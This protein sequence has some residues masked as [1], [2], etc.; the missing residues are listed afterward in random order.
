LRYV[1]RLCGA[2]WL[3]GGRFGAP[4]LYPAFCRRMLH[5]PRSAANGRAP[6]LR[7]SSSPHRSRSAGLRRGPRFVL[8]ASIQL[9]A[10]MHPL[11]CFLQPPELLLVVEV[12][13]ILDWQD[14]VAQSTVVLV[15]IF[16]DD[17]RRLC[18]DQSLFL[19]LRNVLSYCID[20]HADGLADGPIAW[21][22]LI[23]SAVLTVKQVG[24]DRQ[25]AAF[26]WGEEEQRNERVP[27]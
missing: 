10:G 23:G 3:A 12:H 9:P 7:R 5:I 4:G 14:G 24:I 6:S 20:T 13:R 8:L 27:P 16:C 22:A 26:V 18:D 21:I 17:G 15:A 11:R 19:Q 1:F 2:M 25:R